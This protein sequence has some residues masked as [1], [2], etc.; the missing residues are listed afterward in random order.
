MSKI[1][2]KARWTFV[3]VA[4][5]LAAIFTSYIFSKQPEPV[6]AV[7]VVSVTPPIKKPLQEKPSLPIEKPIQKFVITQSNVVDSP[8]EAELTEEIEDEIIEKKKFVLCEH[9]ISGVSQYEFTGEIR[10]TNKGSESINGWT[11][12]WEYEDGAT[13]FEST[14]VALSGNNPYTGEYLSWNTEIAP[15]KTVKFSFSGLKGD[16]NAP[17]GVRVS[18]EFCM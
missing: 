16:E 2:I 5:V 18:G 9:I 12:H 3:L 8:Q 10:M 11:V 17:L 15:G 6:S 7:P 4:L 13:I 1:S 14:D